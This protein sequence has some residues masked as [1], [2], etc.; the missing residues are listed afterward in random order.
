MAEDGIQNLFDADAADDFAD[1]P[2]SFIKI[3]SDIFR[4]VRVLHGFTRAIAGFEGASEA[5]A[6]AEV[7]RQGI[8]GLQI[9]F[10]DAGK[11]FAFES[12]QAVAGYA[13]K[14]N[15]IDIFPFR[16]FG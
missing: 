10:A 15:R 8:L 11:N 4:G 7:D 13:R 3:Q 14:P 9:L 2:E 5:I 12:V 16:M 1:R 6:M